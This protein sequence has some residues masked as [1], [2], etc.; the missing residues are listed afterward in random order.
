MGIIRCTIKTTTFIVE[1]VVWELAILAAIF[2]TTEPGTYASRIIGGM[3]DI[4]YAIY[5]FIRAYVLNVSFRDFMENF[6]TAVVGELG[7]FADNVE[8]DP[9]MV[10]IAF[11][12]TFITYKVLSWLLGL[13]RRRL[14]CRKPK[15]EEPRKSHLHGKEKVSKTYEQLYDRPE[16]PAHDAE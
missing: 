6:K 12:A 13:F 8:A 4:V 9:R 10:L 1:K 5:A 11:I 16:P 15:G 7:K 14:L 2:S 3:E